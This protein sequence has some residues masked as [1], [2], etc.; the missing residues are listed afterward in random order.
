[1]I[2]VESFLSH[3]NMQ[4]PK[5]LQTD[6]IPIFVAHGVNYASPD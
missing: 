6:V 1:M 5:L 2:K 3:F 4:T